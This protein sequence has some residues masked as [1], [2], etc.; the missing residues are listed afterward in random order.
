M[1]F[2]H[3]SLSE[4]QYMITPHLCFSSFHTAKMVLRFCEDMSSASIPKWEKHFLKSASGSFYVRTENKLLEN[5]CIITMY[6]TILCEALNYLFG[7]LL[8][9]NE[10]RKTTHTNCINISVHILMTT[11]CRGLCVCQTCIQF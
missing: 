7:H 1:S 3:K 5:S 2:N 9:L 8:D 6:E 11:V 4:V 10:T